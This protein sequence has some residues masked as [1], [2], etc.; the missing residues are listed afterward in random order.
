MSATPLA[1]FTPGEQPAWLAREAPT[2]VCAETDAELWFPEKGSGSTSRIAKRLCR[3]CPLLAVCR[4]Y[5]LTHPRETRFG[6]WG[7]LSEY[8]RRELR[9]RRRRGESIELGEVAA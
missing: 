1:V 8:E 5:A 4:D 7:G 2:A 9:R 3:T 6:I